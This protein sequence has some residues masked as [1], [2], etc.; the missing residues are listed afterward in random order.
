MARTRYARAATELGAD[1]NLCKVKAGLDRE[2]REERT[3]A[4]VCK[5]VSMCATATIEP[6]GAQGRWW[7]R[8]RSESSS[9]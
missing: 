8:L 3:V 4:C 7:T 6:A 1:A 2:A 5:A 9:G